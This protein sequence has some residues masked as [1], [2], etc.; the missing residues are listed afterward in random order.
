[1]AD[2]ALPVGRVILE[3]LDAFDR[4]AGPYGLYAAEEYRMSRKP[5]GRLQQEWQLGIKP[6]LEA[7]GCRITY[8]RPREGNFLFLTE[9]GAS[10]NLRMVRTSKVKVRK[11]GSAYRVDDHQRY[12]DRWDELRL[13]RE[14][15]D[16][17]K[18]SKVDGKR[19][20]YGIFILIGFA[21]EDP[22]FGKEL[23]E[24][25][26]DVDWDRRQVSYDTMTWSDRYGRSF[27]VRL[28]S[29]SRWNTSDGQSPA[30]QGLPG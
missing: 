6:A 11:F 29:W 13:D 25:K 5:A 9:D 12:Q 30:V 26:R 7:A 8:G 21:S 15:S 10:V 22:P 19:L 2:G 3:A 16:L 18:P 20:S 28:S 17:W 24:L 14:L 27:N 4:V 23:G 1:M